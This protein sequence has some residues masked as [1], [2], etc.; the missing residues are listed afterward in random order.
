VAIITGCKTAEKSRKTQIRNEIPAALTEKEII[1]RNLTNQDFIIQKA[2]IEVNNESDKI[3]LFA[4]I[5]YKKDGKYLISIKSR[6]GIELVRGY[7]TNDTILVN[8]RI[9]KK[10]FC[11]SPV[12]L[13]KKYGISVSA[14]PVIFGDLI[15]ENERLM[16]NIECKQGNSE[17]NGKIKEK[18][19]KYFID[20]KLGKIANARYS[21]ENN[22]KGI[23]LFFDDFYNYNKYNYPRAIKITDSCDETVIKVEI[24][25]VETLIEEA[26]KFVPGNNYEKVILK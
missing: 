15:D 11:G 20:C 25:K 7:I 10:L 17:I 19:I 16:E 26:I 5:K 3:N 14:I 23:E 22:E 9:N 2:E 8:D 13:E 1:S 18:V 4:N 12:Y 21:N 6:S 24:K